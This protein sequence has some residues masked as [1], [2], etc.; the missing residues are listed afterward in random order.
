MGATGDA[1]TSHKASMNI[2]ISRGETPATAQAL[3]SITVK[4]VQWLFERVCRHGYGAEHS[5]R[6]AV[7]IGAIRMAQAG[8]TRRAI[9]AAFAACTSIV[10]PTGAAAKPL[11]AAETR[12]TAL[13]SRMSGW[14]DAVPTNQ[15]R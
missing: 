6:V 14:A 3:D 8:A 4:R 7:E 13:L 10:S 11:I 9:R 2:P 15:L 1:A 5:L 12:I